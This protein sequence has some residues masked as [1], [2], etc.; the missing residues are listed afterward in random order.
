[1]GLDLNPNKEDQAKFCVGTNSCDGFH[2]S[3]LNAIVHRTLSDGQFPLGPTDSLTTMLGLEDREDDQSGPKVSCLPPV[4][5]VLSDGQFP[6]IES[7]SDTHDAAWTG[8]NNPGN[9]FS[10]A[11][12]SSTTASVAETFDLEDRG[13]DPCGPK[14]PVLS[15]KG[16]DNMEDSMG[17]L[18]IPFINF[19]RSLNK[20]FLGSSH[21]LDSFSEYNP[22]YIS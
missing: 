2:H 1:M 11:A 8:E 4:H 22:I 18:G 5:R 20:N 15:S 12:D 19:Y 16:S 17:W 7:L 10:V 21:K 14:V 3:E 6:L 13:K 9:A